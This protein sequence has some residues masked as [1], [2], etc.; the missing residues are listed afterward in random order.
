MKQ[1]KQD[2]V[3]V[4]FRLPARLYK[5][6]EDIS[7]LYDNNLTEALVAV[8]SAFEYSPEHQKLLDKIAVMTY[9][10]KLRHEQM[11]QELKEELNNHASPMP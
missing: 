10:I 1:R 2:K 5:I 4:S 8:L 9:R 3:W 7:V 6:L 11:I